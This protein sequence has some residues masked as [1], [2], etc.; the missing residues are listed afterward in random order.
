[1]TIHFRLDQIE[2]IQYEFFYSHEQIVSAVMMT[3]NTCFILY[4]QIS[5]YLAQL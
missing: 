4:R 3:V 2:S 1:M 5:A